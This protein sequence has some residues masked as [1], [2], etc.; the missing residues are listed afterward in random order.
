MNDISFHLLLMDPVETKLSSP[1][2][3]P[4]GELNLLQTVQSIAGLL[5]TTEEV[6]QGFIYTQ[7]PSFRGLFESCHKLQILQSGVSRICS[8]VPPYFQFKTY[9]SKFH[10][11][12]LIK[13]IR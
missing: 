9:G 12:G 1:G 5:F 7:H 6:L 2:S 13:N 10:L 3:L 11:L 8:A 4:G